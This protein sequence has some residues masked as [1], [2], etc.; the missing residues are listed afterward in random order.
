MITE[1]KIHDIKKSYMNAEINYMGNIDYFKKHNT[2]T[3]L[4]GVN[5]IVGP[6]GSGKSSILYLLGL[7]TASMQGGYSKITN[8]WLSD[9]IGYEEDIFEVKH[10]NQS[11]LFVDSKKQSG[12]IGGGLDDDFMIEG[13]LEIQ[14]KKS[15][16]QMAIQRLNKAIAILTQREVFPDF[17]SKDFISDR[18]IL[19]SIEELKYAKK[20][21]KESIPV[22]QPTIILD[23]PEYGLGYK[24]QF[25]VLRNIITQ[26]NKNNI[27]VIMA[28]HSMFALGYSDVNYVELEEGYI[29]NSIDCFQNFIRSINQ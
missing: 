28:S 26:A 25:N 12:I 5:I 13:I 22:S 16:G 3:F 19:T 8:Q 9:I 6:N 14:A 2:I 7:A 23:E 21:L 27:Q 29:D 10:D 20:L 15:S 1:L 11:T 4:P 17:N 18:G 24:Y